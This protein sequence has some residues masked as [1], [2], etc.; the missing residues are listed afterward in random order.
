LAG[1]KENVIIGNLIPA[2]TGFQGSPKQQLI[3]NVQ[4]DAAR[5]REE[6]VAQREQ[7]AAA[8]EEQAATESSVSS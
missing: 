8:S 4:Q 3:E 1:L 5:R 6:Q 7:D 2:G